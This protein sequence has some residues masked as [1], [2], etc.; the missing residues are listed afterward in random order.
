M[1]SS[2]LTDLKDDNCSVLD[3]TRRMSELAHRPQGREGLR[4]TA[5]LTMCSGLALAR[6]CSPSSASWCS[7]RST[8]TTSASLPTAKPWPGGRP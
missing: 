6:R 8:A 2:Y 4:V 7:R 1:F 3:N 5:S